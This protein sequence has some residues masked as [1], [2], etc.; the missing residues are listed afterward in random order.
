MMKTGPVQRNKFI[1]GFG[2]VGANY[3]A[4]SCDAARKRN[5]Y[6]EMNNA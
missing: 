4:S 6:C 2:E 3:L 1:G 5:Y